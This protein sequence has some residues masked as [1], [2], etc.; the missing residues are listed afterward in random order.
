M[1][2]GAVPH[3]TAS[4]CGSAA[5]AIPARTGSRFRSPASVA[6]GAGRRAGRRTRRSSRSASAR[7]IRCGSRPG[8]RSTATTSTATTTPVMAGLTLRHQQ[9][10]PRRGRL[11][12]RTCGSSPSWRMAPPQKRVGFEVDGRQP[13]REGA[14]VLDGEGNEVGRITSGGFS[15]SLQRPIA[16]GYVATALAEPGTALTLEQRGKLFAGDASRQCR[17]SPTAI[18]AKGS[19]R[20]SLYFTRE[21]EWIRV[22]GDV[23]H[24]RHLRP[25]PGS[26]R[27]HRLRRGAR[28]R[29][30]RS[31]RATRRR[32]SNRSRRRRD[33][34]APVARRGDRGQCRRSPTTRR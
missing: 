21:H 26:A 30:Q 1:Q 19:R 15:P 31:P 5:R 6:R 17:S 20:M 8:C 9:A 22:D 32:W 24:G 11:R 29:A 14:L 3:R 7:A 27:R 18:T 28:G 25:C 16:M 12:R 2:G 4:R 23:G 33:V 10:P 13:V 34:Y